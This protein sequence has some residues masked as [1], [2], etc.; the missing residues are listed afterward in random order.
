MCVKVVPSRADKL[1]NALE[2]RPYGA[3]EVRDHFVAVH[4][5][6][7]VLLAV[8]EAVERAAARGGV[9]RELKS[10]TRA[11]ADGILDKIV[12]PFGAP[13]K[14][15]LGIYD[16]LVVLPVA[17]RVD[18]EDAAEAEALHRLE[19]GGDRLAVGM[20]VDPPPITPRLRQV[21]RIDKRSPHGLPLRQSGLF[22]FLHKRPDLTL[23]LWDKAMGIGIRNPDAVASKTFLGV[24]WIL[25]KIALVPCSAVGIGKRLV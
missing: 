13:D 2:K 3:I 21:R 5:V 22:A 14:L 11:L 15:G 9:H 17:A 20:P 23:K 4:D 24:C 25:K 16:V 8:D 1:G 18:H 10:E 6:G 7:L 19:V 12:P